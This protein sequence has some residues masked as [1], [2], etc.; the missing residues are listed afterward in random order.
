M[1]ATASPFISASCGRIRQKC[2][3]SSLPDLSPDAV[4]PA[5]RRHRARHAGMECARR[6]SAA[7]NFAW[8]AASTF[9]RRPPFFDRSGRD[10]RSLP[11]DIRGAR[12][13]AM[14]RRHADDRP[15]LPDRRD[16]VGHARGAVSALA[17]HRAPDFVQLRVAPQ[18]PRCDDPR[19]V[20]QYPHS[21]RNDAGQGR[22]LHASPARQRANDDLRR[23][24][25]LPP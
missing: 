18:Q 10:T 3:T 2:G 22:R 6:A 14:L 8:K 23:R 12:V 13:L 25:A 9:I 4:S 20:R 24:A 7:P 15:H 17:R 16:L 5:L 21:Q 11:R 19:H 1:I